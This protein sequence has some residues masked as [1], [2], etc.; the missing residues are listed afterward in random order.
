MLKFAVLLA[1]LGFGAATAREYPT[2]GVVYAKVRGIHAKHVVEGQ[3]AEMRQSFY[4]CIQRDPSTDRHRDNWLVYR[5]CWDTTR[6]VYEAI[7][8]CDWFILE[9]AQVEGRTPPPKKQLKQSRR[10][11][12]KAIA[13]FDKCK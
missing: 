1:A 10:H 3:D 4:V 9:D 11:Q 5:Q 12:R 8:V 2:A 6:E 7:E 13:E